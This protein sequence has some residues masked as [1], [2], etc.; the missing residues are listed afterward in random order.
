MITQIINAFVNSLKG[1]RIAVREEFAFRIE[2][3]ASAIILPLIFYFDFS[4][5]EKGIL[6]L[7]LFIILTVE[8]LNSA[9]EAI[10]DRVSMEHHDLIA[11]AK[12]TA[13]AAVLMALISFGLLFV[14][15]LLG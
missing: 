15:F 10:C 2:I 3:I 5:V 14:Y 12:D 11:K 1:L 13:S 7:N 9:V 4:S 6:I 8:L